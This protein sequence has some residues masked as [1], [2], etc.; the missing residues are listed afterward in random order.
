MIVSVSRRC[1]IPRFQFPWFMERLRAGS[2]ETANPFNR[3][4]IKNVSLLEGDVDLFVFWTRD[5]RN[6]LANAD[7]LNDAGFRFYVMVTVTGYPIQLEPSMANQKKVLNAMKELAKKIGPDRVIWRYDPVLL[8][9]I[10]NADSHRANFDFMAQKL[11]GS[12]RR[13]IIS[14]YD[15]YKGSKKRLDAM[16]KFGGLQ[17]MDTGILPDLL[18]GF[19]QSANA[20]GME[21]QSC[22]RKED[23]S[24]YGIKPGACI[25]I[26]LI[27]KLWP[28][29]FNNWAGSGKDKNQRPY[30][31]CNKS[32]DIG[33]YGI[34][35]AHCVYCYAWH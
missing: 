5:P 12:V 31:L 32:V 14:I 35:N 34:C 22:A 28:C 27:N 33:A 29:R 20:A 16:E 3:N 8:T 30:C 17:L 15:E 2:C 25:D 26:E 9:N 24:P 21:I 18:R 4:L 1:D 23:F 10:S 11:A 13:V 6:I 7:E 19:A